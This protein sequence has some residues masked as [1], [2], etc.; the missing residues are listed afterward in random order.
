MQFAKKNHASPKTG[1][2][3]HSTFCFLLWNFQHWLLNPP[4]FRLH[5]DYHSFG[6]IHHLSLCSMG[7]V[8]CTS[9]PV[10]CIK[11]VACNYVSIEKWMDDG[12]TTHFVNMRCICAHRWNDWTD[13]ALCEY[14]CWCGV[15]RT[16][17]NGSMNEWTL[18][19]MFWQRI[20]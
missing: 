18:K 13:S 6:L 10:H 2:F 20:W 3:D 14:G 7:C 1:N 9:M 4:L 15:S 11:S 5:Y 17:R 19:S 16:D 8:R 12:Y